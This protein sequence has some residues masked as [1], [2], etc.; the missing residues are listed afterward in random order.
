MSQQFRFP[1]VGG[2]LRGY[3]E[4]VERTPVVKNLGNNF[5]TARCKSEGKP[6][7]HVG[8]QTAVSH[9][10]FEV[11]TGKS[12]SATGKKTAIILQKL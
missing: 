10:T 12:P 2:K 7:R 8:F 5:K 4:A 9:P 1:H 11:K 6:Y 3:S